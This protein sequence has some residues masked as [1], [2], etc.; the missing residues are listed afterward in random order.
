[1]INP[2]D[3]TT[4]V[5]QTLV[6][7]TLLFPSEHSRGYR[8][9]EGNAIS[10]AISIFIWLLDVVWMRDYK[11]IKSFLLH[12]RR[13]LPILM[14]LMSLSK[15]TFRERLNSVSGGNRQTCRMFLCPCANVF[16]F[17]VVCKSLGTIHAWLIHFGKNISLPSQLSMC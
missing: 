13:R 4:Q 9:V 16:V 14:T 1:M 2:R 15:W 7:S 11:H 3:K 17:I 12:E 8:D 6:T 10:T 5:V